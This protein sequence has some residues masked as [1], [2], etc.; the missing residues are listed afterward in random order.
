MLEKHGER[1]N[2]VGDIQ[3]RVEIDESQNDNVVAL[4][5]AA[6]SRQWTI[7]GISPD[8][9][10][11][12]REAARRSGMKLNS[13]VG[14]ALQRAAESERSIEPDSEEAWAKKVEELEGYIKL[15]FEKLRA[16][17]TQI[18]STINSI[19]SILLKLSVK[20]DLI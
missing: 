12:S 20:N 14:N 11:V 3:T 16:Q 2:G 10:A 7:K 13:W 9:V 1:Q 17:G 19:S 5:S 18:E 4:D 6:Q 15:E 8:A